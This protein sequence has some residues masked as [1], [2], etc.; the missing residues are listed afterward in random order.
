[1]AHSLGEEGVGVKR[2]P[3]PHPAEKAVGAEQTNHMAIKQHS[4][5]LLWDFIQAAFYWSLP[6]AHTHTFI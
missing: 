4:P 1:M 6:H 2:S 5:L 3:P